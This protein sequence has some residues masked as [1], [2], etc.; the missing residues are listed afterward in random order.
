MSVAFVYSLLSDIATSWMLPR[1]VNLLLGVCKPKRR[2]PDKYVAEFE[3]KN[4]RLI[5][6]IQVRFDMGKI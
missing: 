1:K 6:E 2:S 5:E 4:P 3:K